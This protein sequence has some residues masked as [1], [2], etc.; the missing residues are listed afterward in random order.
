MKRGYNIATH[1]EVMN[2]SHIIVLVRSMFRTGLF[3]KGVYMK[4]WQSHLLKQCAF[5][6]RKFYMLTLFF[7]VLLLTAILH[8]DAGENGERIADEGD[9]PILVEDAGGNKRL[10]KDGSRILFTGELYFYLPQTYGNRQVRVNQGNWM[11]VSGGYYQLKQSAFELEQKV[12][13]SFKAY[14]CH[15]NYLMKTYVFYIAEDS[16][17]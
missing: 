16:E 3:E 1:L 13:I 9:L 6:I 10:F 11:K 2:I 15:G 12:S 7:L 4:V 17:K 14:D 5:C 8:A